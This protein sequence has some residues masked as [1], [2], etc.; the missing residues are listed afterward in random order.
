MK[1]GHPKN[2]RHLAG[3]AVSLSGWFILVVS[4]YYGIS[5]FYVQE[6]ILFIF[7]SIAEK[8]SVQELKSDP[9]RFD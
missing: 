2:R 5:I 8:V 7:P 3:I 6:R 1:Q 4:L 9:A